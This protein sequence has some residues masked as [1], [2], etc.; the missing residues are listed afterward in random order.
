MTAQIELRLELP[1]PEPGE[2][3]CCGKPAIKGHADYLATCW[4]CAEYLEAVARTAAEGHRLERLRQAL[5]ERSYDD[6]PIMVRKAPQ[7][8]TLRPV[9]EP[10]K[11]GGA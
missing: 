4:L 11:G 9:P 1:C 8:V 2:C 7:V 10:E 5:A 3:Y 6:Q